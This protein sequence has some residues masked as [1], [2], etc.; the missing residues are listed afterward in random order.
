MLIRLISNIACHPHPT[1]SSLLARFYFGS[2]GSTVE[3]DAQ[4]EFAKS[5]GLSDHL[6][7]IGVIYLGGGVCSVTRPTYESRWLPFRGKALECR[8]SPENCYPHEYAVR[9]TAD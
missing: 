6:D 8:D 9:I 2:R 4:V 1:P 5:T 7:G 3:L